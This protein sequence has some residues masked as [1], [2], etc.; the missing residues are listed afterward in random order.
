MPR[1]LPV[2]TARVPPMGERRVLWLMKG[3]GLGGAERILA[4]SVPALRA[5]GWD[6]E[7]AYVLPHKDAWVGTL[8]DAGVPVH[9]LGAPASVRRWPVRLQRLLAAGDFDVVHSHSPVSA[10]AARL[11]PAGRTA[12]HVHTE[13]NVWSR[14][15]APTRVANAAT[16][17]RVSHLFAVSDS[18][19]GSI[20]RPRWAPWVR[21]PPCEVLHHGIDEAEVRSGP[22]AR[23]A[24]RAELGLPVG[25]P[26]VGTVG[27]LVPKKDHRSLIE[28]FAGVA[29]DR[30]EARLVIVGGGPLEA[31]LRSHAEARGVGDRVLFTGQRA[32]VAGLLPA[33]DTFVLSSR[34]EGLPL[35]LLEAMAS[36]VP[37][38]ATR[39][40]GCPEVV[41]DDADG[42]LVEPG[43][44]AALAAAISG[45]LDDPAGAARLAAAGQ[46]TAGGFSIAVAVERMA[47]V[48]EELLAR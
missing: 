1:G 32:G 13:H 41:T 31:E 27:N 46:T 24:G 21:L 4:M 3:L 19:A 18:V 14:F 5:A 33:F 29:S 45:I 12:A 36:G 39:V 2:P 28:A 20:H 17:G 26:V 23:A 35:A 47:A 30:P 8:R 37:V 38:V 43:D 25:A 9:C 11:T 15:R 22:E 10:A 16:L 48:Y 6:V 34:H 42:R 7:V 40:G 44:V